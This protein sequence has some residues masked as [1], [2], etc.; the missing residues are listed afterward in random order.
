MSRGIANLL[1]VCVFFLLLML[2]IM[3]Y[4]VLKFPERN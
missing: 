2:C 4:S 3:M 1:L